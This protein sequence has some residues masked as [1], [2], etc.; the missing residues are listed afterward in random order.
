MADVSDRL[1][2]SMTSYRAK[3]SITPLP[4]TASA[5][6]GISSRR[7]H[8][9]WAERTVESWAI[10]TS[11]NRFRMSPTTTKNIACSGQSVFHALIDIHHFCNLSRRKHRYWAER[12]VESWAI[13]TSTNRFRMSPTT[14]KNIVC[15][16]QSVFHALIDIH[17]FCNLSRRKHRCWAERTVELWATSNKCK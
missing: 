12:T 13:R 14:T 2:R 9:Y 15:S 17:H 11:A 4:I 10:R 1:S 7:K 3:V 6:I 5:V 16:G 8:R